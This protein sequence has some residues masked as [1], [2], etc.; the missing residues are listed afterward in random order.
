[1]DHDLFLTIYIQQELS[2]LAWFRDESASRCSPCPAAG[3]NML[4][5]DL[6]TLRKTKTSVHTTLIL[7]EILA[8]LSLNNGDMPTCSAWP[9]A[10]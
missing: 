4:W 1:M 5:R 8:M 7:L 10:T 2:C 6:D 3:K 9:A